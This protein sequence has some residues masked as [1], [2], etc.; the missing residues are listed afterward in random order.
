MS[1]P[2]V[3]G[4]NG[5]SWGRQLVKLGAFA[6]PLVVYLLTLAP[7]IIWAHDGADGG[8]LITTA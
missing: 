1:H 2:S 6:L 8:D 3:C 7:T 4:R 5:V